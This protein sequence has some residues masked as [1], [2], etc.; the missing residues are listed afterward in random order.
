MPAYTYE[1]NDTN[2]TTVPMDPGSMDPM[3]LWIYEY[4]GT[5]ETYDIT[6][7]TYHHS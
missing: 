7:P 5:Y 2:D 4:Y 1:P 3:D 6:I